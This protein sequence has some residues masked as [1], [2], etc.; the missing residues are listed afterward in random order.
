MNNQLI[1]ITILFLV[2]IL[3]FFSS[4]N[5][6]K[7]DGTTGGH[8]GIGG[9]TYPAGCSSNNQTCTSC[10]SPSTWNIISGA[11]TTTKPY[12]YGCVNCIQP[13]IWKQTGGCVY[14]DPCAASD[15]PI[16]SCAN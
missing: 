5:K 11:G 7:F 10:N 8:G 1:F 16:Y 12:V 13:K 14:S 2:V 15:P 3:Q 9:I 6:E 4:I